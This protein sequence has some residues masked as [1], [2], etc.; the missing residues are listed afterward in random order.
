MISVCILAKNEEN[1][2]LDCL[3]SVK[4]IA[5]E[6]IVVNNGSTDS[7][8]KIALD[9]GCKVIDSPDTVLDLGRNIYLDE[10]KFPWILVMDADERLADNCEE[11]ILNFIKNVDDN[12]LGI[13]LNTYQ[14]IGNGRWS[15]LKLIRLIK[16]NP[17]IRYQNTPIHSDIETSI[18]NNNGIIAECNSSVH[19]IDILLNNRTKFKREKY[20]QHLL[21]ILKTENIKS[22]KSKGYLYCFLGLEFSAFDDFDTAENLYKMVIS[23]MPECADFAKVFL[24]QNFL[25]KHDLDKAEHIIYSIDPKKAFSIIDQILY[26]KLQI[27]YKKNKVYDAI[28]LLLKN[29]SFNEFLSH[30]F[31]NLAILYKDIDPLKS[32]EFIEKAT[33]LNNYLNY[34]F[35]YKD[36][37]KPNI[38]FQQSCVLESE[39]NIFEIMKQCCYKTNQISR[40]EKWCNK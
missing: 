24:A 7:T 5:S 15:N 18:F 37:E 21:E 20:K 13:T 8:K 31:V 10:A 1:L 25:L 11:D 40:F 26:V 34:S 3:K 16:N 2:I 12:V 39:L 32:I 29:K 33:N 27:L 30:D 38:F 17:N 6:I 23:E 14:Y 9:F 22:E 4:K 35:I 19:H 28:D 36:G